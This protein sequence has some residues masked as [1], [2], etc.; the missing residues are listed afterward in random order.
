MLT[1]CKFLNKFMFNQIITN[2]LINNKPGVVFQ[3]RNISLFLGEMRWGNVYAGGSN[4]ALAVGCS[5]P[6]PT[7]CPIGFLVSFQYTMK[8][9][10]GK[11]EV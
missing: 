8:T 4:E 10:L 11:L 1:W 6:V 5:G 2:S 3:C 9:K 7:F